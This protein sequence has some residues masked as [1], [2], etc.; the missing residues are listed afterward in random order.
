M[1][2]QLGLYAL[3]ARTE[4]E[5]Q[6]ERGLVRYLNPDSAEKA[7]LDIPLDSESLNKA[8]AVVA[9][10]AQSIRKREFMTGPRR[11]RDGKSRCPDCDFFSF[12]GMPDA[13]KL[14]R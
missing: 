5:Y 1:R 2:L 4:L 9:T 11:E 13:L 12:C 10:T 7:Q 3:A 14:K 8:R 6:P